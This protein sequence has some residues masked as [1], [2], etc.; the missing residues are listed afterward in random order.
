M[1]AKPSGEVKTRIVKNTQKNGDIY[2]L[3]RQ[4][5]YDTAK[6]CNK[7]ISSKLI[8]K[9]PKGSD[10]Q[11]QTRPKR[12]SSGSEHTKAENSASRTHVGMM[13]IIG[14]IGTVSG[15]DGGI[16]DATDTGTAQ[17]II[18]LSRY[19]LATNGQSL[20][21]VLTWQYNHPLPYAEGMTEEIYHELFARIGRDESLQQ[22]FFLSRCRDLGEHEA[23]AYDS[24]TISTYSENQI[25]ARYGF[26]K[27]GDG[28]KTIKLLTLYSIESRQPIAFTKQPGNLP[29]VITIA[30]ALKQ[31][32]ALGINNTEIVT[33]NGYYS[34]QN[35]S[36]FFQS[37]FD[38]LTLVKTSVKWV[39][40]EIDSHMKEFNS[41]SSVCPF[42]VSTHGVTV[43]LKRGFMK[44][45]KYASKVNGARKGD[46][47]IFSRRI[48][49]SIYFNSMRQSEDKI[50]FER[51]LFEI[52]TLIESGI[53]VS[54][55]SDDAQSK[56]KKYMSVRSHSG[57]AHVGF[58]D[59][60]CA[61][62]YKY[63]GYF[64][65]VSNKENEPFECLRKYRRR[66]TIESFFEAGKQHADGLRPRVWDT[67]TLRGRMFV[68]FVSL[69][70]YEYFGDQ[71]RKLKASLGK[72]T[73]DAEHDKKAVLDAEKK[74]YSWLGNTP[75]YLQ[76]QWFDTVESVSISSV[77][78]RKRWNTEITSR[79]SLYLNK[80][81]VKI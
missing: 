48:Y 23:L 46:E 50:A 12:A 26:N 16:Y 71:I 81:G 17:K 25:E 62:A 8:A 76:L 5:I 31:L 55:L 74:L 78:S 33:D 61:E 37:G 7:V 15:I 19:L 10:E 59:K 56:V 68:Q 47:E 80:L 28:L 27:A 49:L 63:H 57:K 4:T 67:D 35:L 20:P 73:G 41:I 6:K 45:R 40:A 34:E 13:D 42:D 3:E 2:V 32:S 9:I 38:F 72:K 79:D 54:E 44:T 65:L 66:E 30:N 39:R 69:C 77:L 36:E 70:Y 64:A 51:N 14:H 21:G 58:D 52:K 29:D 43:I 1:P 11:T 24:S 75:L 18:S 53:P 22:N 60:A